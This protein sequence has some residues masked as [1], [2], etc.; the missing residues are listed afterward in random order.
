MNDLLPIDHLVYAVPDLAAGVD[1][2]E[3]LLGVRPAPGGQHP[4][5]GTANALLAL[6]PTMYLEVIGPDP[7][8]PPHPRPFG[9]DPLRPGRLAGWAVKT[10]DLDARIRASAAR[11]YHPGRVFPGSRRRPDGTP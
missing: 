5:W 7:D 3:R 1:A 9:V 6:G 11:G 4:G 10:A 8:Q 2:M